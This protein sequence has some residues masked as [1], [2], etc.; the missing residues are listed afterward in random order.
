MNATNLYFD[1]VLTTHVLIRDWLSG[2]VT[3]P[4]HCTDLLARFSPAFTMVAPVGKQLDGAG[5]AAFFRAA[6][7]SRPGLQMHI[8]DLVLIQ[9]S[10]AGATV[11]YREFQAMPGAENTE[12]LSTVVYD[13]TPSGALLWR[14][15]HETWVA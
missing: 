6:G 9:E 2:D 4:E 5:L 13:K 3:A 10:A 14:H 1:D 15:L 12:R 11:S 7:G 8:S